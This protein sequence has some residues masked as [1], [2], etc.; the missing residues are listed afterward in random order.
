MLSKYNLTIIMEWF[1]DNGENIL[2]DLI[3][4]IIKLVEDVSELT[5][6]NIENWLENNR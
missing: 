3:Q 5:P 1:D 6:D 4:D 2:S